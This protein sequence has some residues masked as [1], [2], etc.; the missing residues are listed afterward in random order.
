MWPCI[1]G[2]ST[3]LLIAFAATVWSFVRWTDKKSKSIPRSTEWNKANG[4]RWTA[5]RWFGREEILTPL[6]LDKLAMLLIHKPGEKETRQTVSATVLK[7]QMEM[8]REK[9][10]P[11]FKVTSGTKI[12]EEFWVRNGFLSREKTEAFY[13]PAPE[14]DVEV[15]PETEK[16]VIVGQEI[17]LEEAGVT[18]DLVADR[19]FSIE[20]GSFHE[21]LALTCMP[22]EPEMLALTYAA[23]TAIDSILKTAHE[24]LNAEESD[25]RSARSQRPEPRATR[26]KNISL[27]PLENDPEYLLAQREETISQILLKA[28]ENRGEATNIDRDIEIN[29]RPQII[30]QKKKTLEAEREY[31]LARIAVHAEITGIAENRGITLPGHAGKELLPRELVNEEIRELAS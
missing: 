20:N 1:I 30:E 8:P 22:D 16:D 24:A 27:P 29:L 4:K 10:A 28:A 5:I 15:K 14:P 12:L 21:R 23:K 26:P 13:A 2:G 7:D 6:G 11:A 18:G 3:V 19:V 17:C 25:P 31:L 9:P